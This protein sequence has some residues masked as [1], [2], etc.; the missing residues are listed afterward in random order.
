MAGGT[1]ATTVR[2]AAVQTLLQVACAARYGALHQLPHRDVFAAYVRCADMLTADT[3][4]L[5]VQR[6]CEH[7]GPAER[8]GLATI[9]HRAFRRE[10][11]P[12]ARVWARI[13]PGQAS[14][15]QIAQLYR[16][17]HQ[18]YP[19]MLDR[20]FHPDGADATQSRGAVAGIT[21]E[22]IGTILGP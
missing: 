16:T 2:P 9:L 1:G 17:A 15:A 12:G 14:A 3:L 10:T 21:A 11:G 6:Y 22:A 8:G 18:H 4:A 19:G 7:A 5:A 13:D 20:L